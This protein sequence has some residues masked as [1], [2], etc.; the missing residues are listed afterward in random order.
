MQA[1]KKGRPH[2][3]SPSPAQVAVCNGA[4]DDRCHQWATNDA[5][6]VTDHGSCAIPRR[7]QVGQHAARVDERGGGE[8]S[9]PEA[10]Q[11]QRLEVFPCR[12]TECEADGDE[13]GDLDCILAPVDFA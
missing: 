6:L 5:H 12:F 7:E 8:E 11:H 9:T 2:I 13:E 4:T 10:T 3:A 1:E